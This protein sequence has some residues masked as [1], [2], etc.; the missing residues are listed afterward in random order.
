LSADAQKRRLPSKFAEDL[1][2][3]VLSLKQSPHDWNFVAQQTVLPSLSEHF[4]VVCFSAA[5]THPLMWAHY[6]AQ[7]FG[8]MV[9]FDATA[10]LFRSSAF[11]RVDY[12]VDRS[13][14]VF[15]PDLRQCSSEPTS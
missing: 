12:R 5:D 8:L 13:R 4:G 7:H 14:I 9:E 2:D 10:P 6:A 15:S 3:V 1:A 11:I